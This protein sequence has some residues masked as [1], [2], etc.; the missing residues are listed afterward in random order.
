ML[1]VP[2]CRQVPKKHWPERWRKTVSRTKGIDHVIL[3]NG[4][5]RVH[6]RRG[7]KRGWITRWAG[8]RPALHVEERVRFVRHGGINLAKTLFELA[9]ATSHALNL[10]KQLFAIRQGGSFVWG[11]RCQWSLW[12]QGGTL[13]VTH[14]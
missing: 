3:V 9:N 13:C 10:S 6:W 12:C 14:L 2:R 5:V 1:S 7:R 4:W 8:R 11:T